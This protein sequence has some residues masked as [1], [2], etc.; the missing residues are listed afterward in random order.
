MLPFPVLPP[1]P[2]RTHSLAARLPTRPPGY[3]LGPI[4]GDHFLV[5]V[6]DKCTR[7][8]VATERSLNIMMFDMDPAVASHFYMESCPDKE[9]AAAAK[10]M[11]ASS[12]IDNLVPGAGETRP[13]SAVSSSRTD[14]P[15]A[16]SP[17]RPR[18]RPLH[19]LVI[20]DRAFDPC[21]YSMNAILYGR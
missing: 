16:H 19:P 1:C 10:H 18:L 5:Y 12:G 14:G 20:D 4:T 8:Y 2:R 3:I 7:Q 15:V 21:G 6:A 13:A 17:T 9:D 11:T